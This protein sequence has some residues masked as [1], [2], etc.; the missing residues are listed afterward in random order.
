V[1]CRSRHDFAARLEKHWRRHDHE[2]IDARF[3]QQSAQFDAKL[4]ELERRMTIRLGT[5]TVAA[6]SIVSAI[7]KLL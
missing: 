7:V 1:L 5:V 2:R 4:A 3:G 6:V